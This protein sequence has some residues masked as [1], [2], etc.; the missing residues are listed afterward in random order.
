MCNWLDR[1]LQIERRP[2]VLIGRGARKCRPSPAHSRGS[3]CVGRWIGPPRLEQQRRRRV[4]DVVERRGGRR[5]EKE[6]TRKKGGGR[7]GRKVREK[8]S[9]KRHGAVKTSVVG[10]SSP[11]SHL[12]RAMK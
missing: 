8:G 7:D 10:Q 11:A 12:R 1:G 4:P 2:Q 6:G 9:E 5:H 3:G